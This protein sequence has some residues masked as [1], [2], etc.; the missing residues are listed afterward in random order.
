MI[1]SARLFHKNCSPPSSYN[2]D[3]EVLWGSIADPKSIFLA[4]HQLASID[5]RPPVHLWLSKTGLVCIVK[6]PEL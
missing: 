4:A 2:G 5:L 3:S 6:N 1:Q